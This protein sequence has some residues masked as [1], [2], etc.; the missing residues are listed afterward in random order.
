MYEKSHTIV[1]AAGSEMLNGVGQKQGQNTPRFSHTRRA[2]IIVC[3]TDNFLSD[4][5]ETRAST[6]SGCRWQLI[7]RPGSDS[8]R[9]DVM[10]ANQE[11]IAPAPSTS[12]LRSP[13]RSPSPLPGPRGHF[14]FHIEIDVV[15]LHFTN[16]EREQTGTGVCL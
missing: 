2:P 5:N 15:W 3:K 8:P 12:S 1:L 4:D 10:T 14:I 16:M 11:C 7:A 13:S 9:F 6:D